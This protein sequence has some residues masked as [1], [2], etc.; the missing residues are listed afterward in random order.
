MLTVLEEQACMCIVV[1]CLEYRWGR[2]DGF[3]YV[4]TIDVRHWRWVGWK[5]CWRQMKAGKGMEVSGGPPAHP[6]ALPF[7]RPPSRPDVCLSVFKI[8]QNN[9]ITV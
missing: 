8:F 2:K 1:N 6:Q 7:A 5:K 3:D 9:R 4:Q